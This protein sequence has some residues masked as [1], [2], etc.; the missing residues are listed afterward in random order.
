MNSV[1]RLITKEPVRYHPACFEHV[2]KPRGA[3]HSDPVKAALFR[4]RRLC[5]G[6]EMRVDAQYIVYRSETDRNHYVFLGHV[7]SYR[8]VA[9]HVT[10]YLRHGNLPDTTALLTGVQTRILHFWRD[11]T[12]EHGKPP[13]PSNCADYC[14]IPKTSVSQNLRKLVQRGY[15]EERPVPEAERKGNRMFEFW[16]VEKGE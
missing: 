6:Q 9:E 13:I 8:A 11:F 4:L 16:V 2:V 3:W 12:H 5:P 1:M 14:K 10:E 7:Y 15:M